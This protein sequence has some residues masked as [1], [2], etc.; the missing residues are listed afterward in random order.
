MA[1]N[2]PYFMFGLGGEYAVHDRFRLGL[3]AINGYNNLSHP[4][5]H[6]SYGARVATGRP[7]SSA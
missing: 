2:A 1:D 5:D 3:Y 6:L 7:R 4:N